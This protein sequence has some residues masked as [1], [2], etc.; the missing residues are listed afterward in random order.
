MTDTAVVAK[1]D[2]VAVIES[3][4]EDRAAK[5]MELLPEGMDAKRFMRATMT[6]IARNEDLLKCTP[7]SV[8]LAVYDAAEAGFVPTGA[9]SRAWLIPRRVNVSK[10]GQPKR[11]EW[12]AQLQ[13]GYQ[14]LADLMREG[15]AIKVESRV[16]FEGDLFEVK[17]G[18][19]PD[20]LHIPRFKTVDPD[21]ITHVY[22][23]ATLPGGETL[24]EVLTKEQVDMVRAMGAGNSPAWIQSYPQMARKTAIRRLANYLHLSER[25]QIV[26]ARDDVASVSPHE[27]VEPDR[28]TAEVR[29]KLA[30]KL[31]KAPPPPEAESEIE[32]EVE[33]AEEEID[34]DALFAELD[35]AEAARA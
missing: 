18:T 34:Q 3:A 8:I 27:P 23:V 33:E 20:I 28:R 35:A 6:A 13:I 9:L 24:T 10:H 31:G 25:A 30:E 26:I 17:F 21:Q 16:V 11:Y 19:H 15:G 2:A 7:T 4:L 22:A 1:K 5:L 29:A 14:G 32:P 12:H